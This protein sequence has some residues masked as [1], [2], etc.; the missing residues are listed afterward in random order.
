MHDASSEEFVLQDATINLRHVELDL[1]D[2]LSCDDVEDSGD[3]DCDGDK[4]K[5][6]GPFV[7]NLLTGVSEPSLG[8]IPAGN[9]DRIDFRVDDSDAMGDRSFVASAAFDLDGTATTL[10][11]SLKFNEDIRIEQ[12]GGVDVEAGQDLI[13]S[14]VTNDWLAGVDV[15]QCVADDELDTTGDVVTIDDDTTSGG[16]S[17]IENTIKNNMKKSG[18]LGGS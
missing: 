3:A 16:C 13:A 9:Y 10:V 15:A 4:L 6:Q 2:D 1:P 14:Y 17:D 12:P 18:Q 8:S 11:L 5:L 7:V